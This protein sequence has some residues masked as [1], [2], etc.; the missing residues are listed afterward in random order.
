[1][2]IVLGML[3]LLLLL[4]VASQATGQKD[5]DQDPSIAFE[6][7]WKLNFGVVISRDPLGRPVK[8]QLT[9]D[10][11]GQTNGTLVRV[12]GKDT[13][14]GTT[15]GEF[16]EQGKESENPSIALWKVTKI[17]VTQRLEITTGK[18]GKLD[19]LL[20][21]YDLENTDSR[22]H[23]VGL[24]VMIDSAIGSPDN[25]GVPFR[26]AGGK[27]LVTTFKDFPEG[28][29]P[30]WAEALEKPDQK[31]PGT[32][33]VMTLK[34]G[35]GLEA[36]NRASI[37]MWPGAAPAAWEIPLESFGP[38]GAK[39]DSSLVLYWNPVELKA[40]QKRSLG[41]GYGTQDK[42]SD[43]LVATHAAGDV[44]A[45]T[46]SKKLPPPKELKL[47]GGSEMTANATSGAGRAIAKNSSE[48]TGT[49]DANSE[50]LE[51]LA[52]KA[53]EKLSEKSNGVCCR[54]DLSA[55]YAQCALKVSLGLI[56][57]EDLSDADGDG[58]VT[59][60]DAQLLL[61]KAVTAARTAR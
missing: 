40:G 42:P 24:R 31:E 39:R 32:I 60:R 47:P 23:Q 36:P 51:K 7:D 38:G 61:K 1:M 28:T 15:G 45:E 44:Q 48:K 18:T 17:K 43:L 27:E 29:L 26:Y 30:E 20:V 25:D 59:V 13:E 37:T 54:G 52:K 21:R 8:K 9:F 34:V 19:T 10:T 2:K 49:P 55:Q 50:S 57:R 14:F 41:Y 46:A 53:A 33:T 56:P 5:T 58:Q 22:P 12:D 4:L 35:R 11:M 16:L 3:S 6:Y